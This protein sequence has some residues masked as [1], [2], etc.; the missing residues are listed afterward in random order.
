M[1]IG[2]TQD[3]RKNRQNKSAH[4]QII[5]SKTSDSNGENPQ[6]AEGDPRKNKALANLS[7]LPSK[8]AELY[9]SNMN[10]L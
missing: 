2:K 4:L 7:H 9:Q 3:D 10:H 1:L 5:T 6:L 8:L